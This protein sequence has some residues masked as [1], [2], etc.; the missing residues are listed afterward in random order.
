[1]YFR[2][3]GSHFKLPWRDIKMDSAWCGHG[4]SFWDSVR[5][6]RLTFLLIPDGNYCKKI[7]GTPGSK[8]PVANGYNSH[9]LLR[10]PRR[11]RVKSPWKD[12]NTYSFQSAICSY[13]YW[14]SLESQRKWNIRQNQCKRTWCSE[15]KNL[16]VDELYV[17]YNDSTRLCTNIAWREVLTRKWSKHNE[18]GSNCFNGREA[19][20]KFRG[21]LLPY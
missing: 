13:P 18:W 19:A 15:N 4:L 12:Q 16:I 2:K 5:H 8:P 1:M 17:R 11:L 20:L 14:V 21:Q 7:E 3:I 9:W 6:T 10:E